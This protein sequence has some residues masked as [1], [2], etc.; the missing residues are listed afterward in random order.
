MR[1]AKSFAL[2]AAFAALPRPADAKLFQLYVQGHGGYSAGSGDE[3]AHAIAG[4]FLPKRQ[5]FYKAVSGVAGGA[6][7]GLTVVGIDL[8][9]D[10][11]KFL[12]G[13]TVTKI[14]L[15]MRLHFDPGDDGDFTLFFRAGGGAMIATFGD[16]SP[17]TAE[18]GKTPLGFTARGGL[19]LAYELGGPFEIG[20]QFDVGYYYLLNGTVRPDEQRLDQIADTCGDD[21]ECLRTLGQAL[22][23]EE[24]GVRYETSQGIDWTV[25]FALRAALGF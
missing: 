21:Q 15:G 17:F 1:A 6:E 2:L 24:G 19:G 13:G 14:V 18:V 25:L 3:E 11:L 16:A 7:L 4:S 20:P 9:A 8:C 12:D 10:F 5:D 22:A 23:A